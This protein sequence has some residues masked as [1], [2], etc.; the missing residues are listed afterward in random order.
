[1]F[2]TKC[3]TP[4][5]D[6]S[7]V[8]HKCGETFKSD[9]EPKDT[10]L[11]GELDEAAAEES[12]AQPVVEQPARQS[13]DEPATPQPTQQSTVSSAADDGI[14]SI[15]GFVFAFSAPLIGLILSLIGYRKIK[16]RSLAIA[17][18]IIG[19]VILISLLVIVAIGFKNMEDSSIPFFILISA[20]L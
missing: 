4:L 6:D 2:C 14:I 3:G 5:D 9:E 18:I 13:A 7:T 17:G 1:M 10:V 19:T 16:Y 8:C 12:N 15:I 11:Q 20:L